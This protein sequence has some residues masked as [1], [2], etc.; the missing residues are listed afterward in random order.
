MQLWDYVFQSCACSRGVILNNKEY[1]RSSTSILARLSVRFRVKTS[2]G[3]HTASLPPSLLGVIACLSPPLSLTF[4][5]GGGDWQQEANLSSFPSSL[6]P[7]SYAGFGSASWAPGQQKEEESLSLAGRLTDLKKTVNVGEITSQSVIC[8][9]WGWNISFLVII[10]TRKICF[11]LL[12]NKNLY[13][14]EDGCC[15]FIYI[16]NHPF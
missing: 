16:C 15:V 13:V 3:G 6:R 14:W 4:A 5:T 11:F 10:N 8:Y 7:Q 9:I 2:L 12:L 1:V